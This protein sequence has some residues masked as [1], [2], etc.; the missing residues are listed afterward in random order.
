MRSN[1]EAYRE[2]LRKELAGVEEY[3]AQEEKQED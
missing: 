1:L 2:E 3:L